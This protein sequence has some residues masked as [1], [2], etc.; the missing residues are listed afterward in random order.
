M[1]ALTG[2]A[3]AA[4]IV[5]PPAYDWTGFYAGLNAGYAFDGNDEVGLSVSNGNFLSPGD[6]SLQGWFGGAQAGYNWQS[7]SFVLGVEAD[8]QGGDVSDSFKNGLDLDTS[9]N[10]SSSA[11]FYGTFR[12]RAGFAA[13]RALFYVTGGGAWA[14]VD[15]HIY[16]IDGG[17]NNVTFNNN[18]GLFGYVLGAG[19]E[20]AFDDQWSAKLEYQYLNFGKKKLTEAVVDAGG[21]PNGV[22][23]TTFETPDFSSLRLGVN[24]KF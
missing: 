16:S 18:Q 8:I 6:L 1:L 23:V 4:D 7:S 12:G 21:S 9:T 2:N 13:D 11:D 24:F 14:D 10:A 19:V 20:Y 3:F 5:P 15:Y 22:T 17:G